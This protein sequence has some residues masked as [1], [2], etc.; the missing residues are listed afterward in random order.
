MFDYMHYFTNQKTTQTSQEIKI[1]QVTIFTLSVHT[2]Y[3]IKTKF[4]RKTRLDSGQKKFIITK[5]S[6]SSASNILLKAITLFPFFLFLPF[7]TSN[8]KCK[9]SCFFKN[10]F[11]FLVFPAGKYMLQKARKFSKVGK[12]YYNKASWNTNGLRTSQPRVSVNNSII[13]HQPS[14]TGFYIKRVYSEA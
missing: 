9:K 8:D 10:F 3:F 11:S 4:M 6:L 1:L 7:S 2:R 14:I 13:M 5:S 12:K